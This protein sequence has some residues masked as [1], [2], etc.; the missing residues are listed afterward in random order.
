MNGYKLIIT[1]LF[2]DIQKHEI[3]LLKGLSIPAIHQRRWRRP[4]NVPKPSR[5]EVGLSHFHVE[6]ILRGTPPY[7]CIYLVDGD[8][9]V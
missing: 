4:I 8:I 1:K 5:E 6:E 3:A 2:P 9:Y 7:G